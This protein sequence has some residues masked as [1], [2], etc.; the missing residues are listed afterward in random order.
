MV[1]KLCTPKTKTQNRRDETL[2]AQSL[3]CH[4]VSRTFEILA[5][6]WVGRILPGNGQRLEKRLMIPRL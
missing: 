6:Q 4:G 2:F 1:A 3:K 5:V